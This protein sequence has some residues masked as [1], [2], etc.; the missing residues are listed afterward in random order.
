MRALQ[1]R[2]TKTEQAL[3]Q[4]GHSEGGDL[5]TRVEELRIQQKALRDTLAGAIGKRR[6]IE[7]QFADLQRSQEEIERMLASIE[8][9]GGDLQGRIQKLAQ[10]ID[11][12]N[13]RFDE[14]ERSMEMLI[15]QK[16]GFGVLQAR[17]APLEQNEHGGINH[18]IKVV[19]DLR[20]QLIARV[21]HLDRE[22]GVTLAD[23]VSMLAETKDKLE[24]NI[25]G[26]LDEFSRLD[27]IRRDMTGLFDR[28]N[29]VIDANGLAAGGGRRHGTG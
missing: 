26:L 22:G 14:I 2:L 10:S 6:S 29:E 18:L 11:G 16:R 23:R 4:Q 1:Q 3:Q 25:S 13:P 9:D 28:L 5:L 24:L 15:Q 20:D 21:D 7:Q 8:G 19:H 27:T 17:L 12:T